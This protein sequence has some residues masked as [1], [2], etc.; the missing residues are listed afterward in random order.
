[1][2]TNP[3]RSAS[4][5]CRSNA[6]VNENQRI[7]NHRLLDVSLIGRVTNITEYDKKGRVTFRVTDDLGVTRTYYDGAD[8]VIKTVDSALDNG[9]SGSAFNPANLDGNTV[10]MAYD[11]NGN[12]IETLQTDVTEVSSVADETF[13]TTN[14]YDALDRLTLT[15]DNLGEA[16]YI[17]YDSRGNL[18]ARA[19]ANGPTEEAD[20]IVSNGSFESSTTDWTLGDGW[21][22]YCIVPY[23]NYAVLAVVSEVGTEETLSQELSDLAP[24]MTYSVVL[25]T[26]LMGMDGSLIVGLGEAAP[27]ET[28]CTDL[29]SDYY[30]Y[31][32]TAGT[33]E[34]QLLEIG[35]DQ[36]PTGSPYF[37]V[38]NISVTPL[39]GC[40]DINRRGLG[41]SASVEINGHGN[42]TRTYYDGLSRVVESERL[43][44][45][46]GEGVYIAADIYGVKSDPDA[47]CDTDQGG[48]DGRINEYRAYDDNSQLV[49][50]RDDNGNVTA[51]IYDNQNRVLVERKGLYV[52][53]TTLAVPSGDTVYFNVSLRG[54]AS[55][56][57][58]EAYGTAIMLEYDK[59]GNVT[60]RTDEA[61]NVLEYDYNG[62]SR[63]K[64]VDVTT[65]AS[66][67]V[68]SL[69]QKFQYDGLGRKTWTFD[70]SDDPDT[71]SEAN[72]VT[73]GFDYDSLSRLVEEWQS[74]GMFGSSG[75]RYTTS[76]Y[77]A[78]YGSVSQ[79]SSL[80]YAD[81]RRVDNYY[82]KLDRLTRKRDNGQSSDIGKY[83][84]IGA[85][86][87]ATLT[88]QNLTRLTHLGQVS[89]A[90]ADVGFDGMRRILNHRWEK[91]TGTDTSYGND[92]LVVG[93]EQ[94]DSSGNPLY[95]RRDN[96]LIEYKT[97]D[98]SNSEM[99]Q[100]DSAYRLTS[101][102]T[103][104]QS[105]G[106]RAFER[107]TFSDGDRDSMSTVNYYEDWDLDGLGNWSSVWKNSSTAQTRTHSDF[108]E[109]VNNNGTSLTYDANGNL[110]DDGTNTYGWDPFGRLG[111]V[112]RKS[113]SQ[114]LITCI[115]DADS[116][117]ISKWDWVGSE[118]KFYYYSGW[119]ALEECT[120]YYDEANL[121]RLQRQYVWGGTYLD[122]IWTQDDRWTGSA[123]ISVS[124]LNDGSGTQRLFHCSNT[125]YSVF[126]VT[127][128]SGTLQERYQYAPYGDRTI[129]DSSSNVISSSA[130]NIDYAYT[131]Q[132]LDPETEM[133][134]YKNRYYDVSLGR[135]IARDS[136]GYFGG[137]NLYAYVDSNPIHNLDTYGLCDKSDEECCKW[138]A[139]NDLHKKEKAI[140][141]VICCEGR[142]V[143]CVFPPSG[144]ESGPGNDEKNA[145]VKKHEDEH[146]D[147]I[148][149]CP[150]N[151]DRVT[152]GSHNLTK[153]E[154]EKEE[155]D[156][157]R[158]EIKC[159][160]SKLYNECTKYGTFDE[161]N[162]CYGAVSTEITRIKFEMSPYYHCNP[163]L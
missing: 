37:Y 21:S 158:E 60:E 8:R 25:E 36:S 46:T 148:L 76:Y 157:F 55:I 1:M 30:E 95:D 147:V 86:R 68:G 123:T 17:R 151:S 124:S 59:D 111:F 155:C 40:A 96:K 39:N 49:G 47:F 159:L 135:F 91:F 26:D 58:T 138:A 75:V 100:Y 140:G 41:S 15:V 160:E 87:V 90:N 33:D 98:T 136:I 125:L 14:F 54:G 162:D 122:E 57:N 66:G 34:D 144:Q 92:T 127:D 97:H 77:D 131:G 149:P 139:A 116:R 31:I 2:K 45:E 44:T 5:L 99:Y 23:S 56:V 93:F 84:Y 7:M 61:G 126:A 85:G 129:Y 20:D 65:V 112:M 102:S 78:A 28:D 74:V 94:Q 82:D 89:S 107:G 73:C 115:Y 13:R 119:R 3:Y 48:G 67:Y 43:L 163:R 81:G 4:K 143:S 32:V 12:V 53:G 16:T 64:Q 137:I 9:W 150:K 142:K 132:R 161:R 156:A 113:D 83:Q 120:Y 121:Q 11:D 19:D 50:L 42:V 88:Y 128:E 141:L 10:E 51:Y 109:I 152:V 35:M 105:A 134:Y 69:Q 80:V 103:G 29:G 52:S 62:L 114:Y 146:H 24:G 118:G 108:N 101:T 153:P 79:P 71:G 130:Y 117:R 38:D 22:H 104:T 6:L 27:S 72:D 106:S 145:C 110:T 63:R 154:R 70:A 18:V 133:M